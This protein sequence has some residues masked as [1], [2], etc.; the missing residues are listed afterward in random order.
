MTTLLVLG[1]GGPAGVNFIRALRE[2]NLS[3]RIIAFDRNPYHLKLVEPHADGCYWQEEET[4]E[5]RVD[6]LN[7]LIKTQQVDFIHAQPDSEV[8]FLSEHREAIQAKCCLPT[9]EVIRSCQD[10]LATLNLWSLTGVRTVWH[11]PV[12]MSDIL[13]EKIFPCWLRATRGAGGRGST[14]VSKATTAISWMN[15]W[16]SR[17]MDWDFVAEELLPGRNIAVQTLWQD[18]RLVCSVA[19]E[20]VEYIYPNLAPSG[21]T[22]TPSVARTIVD[23]KHYEE[24]ASQAVMA[25]DSHPQGVYGVDFKEDKNG[26]PQPTEINVGR[27]FTTSL[28]TAHLGCNMPALY[29]RG[30]LGEKLSYINSCETIEAGIHWIR[31]MDSQPV[32]ID[33]ECISKWFLNHRDPT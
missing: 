25:V 5:K 27:F 22:G 29:V 2:S 14:P 26:H 12:D 9:I 28:L 20:R 13:E 15:Y 11:Q 31:H 23:G 8:A 30:L 7:R 6:E 32:L 17:G 21:I 33:E 1:G 19:R 16:R 4:L 18:G 24:T 3:L 10:K